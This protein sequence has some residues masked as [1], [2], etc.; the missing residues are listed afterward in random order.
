MN[1][2]LNEEFVQLN[3]QTVF[4]HPGYDSV[5]LIADTIRHEVRFAPVHQLALSVRGSPLSLTRLIADH[6]KRRAK[7]GLALFIQHRPGYSL[8]R[9][10]GA[11]FDLAP[12]IALPGALDNL[13]ENAMDDQVGIAPDWRRKMSVSL[14]RQPE[15]TR[16]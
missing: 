3:I 12:G 8:N 10:P 11:E 16:V 14:H 9:M 7:L 6:F 2:T 1:E 15:V 13:A 4:L 5:E